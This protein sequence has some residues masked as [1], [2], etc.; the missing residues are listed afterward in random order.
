MT[1]GYNNNIL[2]VNLTNNSISSEQPDETFFR[3]YIGGW[4]IVAYYLLRETKPGIDPLSPDNK[5]IFATSPLS[6]VTVPGSGRHSVGAKSPLT[7]AFGTAEVGGFWGTELKHSGFDAIIIE[8]MASKPV[9]LW[10]HNSVAEIRSAINLWGKTTGD[11]EAELRS[12]LGDAKIKVAAIG[13]AGET[14]V[15]YACIIHDRSRAAGRGGLGAVMG[16]KNLKAIA[17]RGEQAPKVSNPEILRSFTRTI[18]K[19]KDV[20]RDFKDTGTAGVTTVLNA[21]GGLPTRNFQAGTFDLAEE[22]SGE[23]MRDTILTGRGTCAG[24][25]VSCKREVE[26]DGDP[27]KVDATYGGPEYETIG[28]FGSNCGIGSLEMVAKANELCNAY[29]LD[30]ISTGNVIGFAMECFEAGLLTATMTNGLDLRFGNEAA[31]LQAIELLTRRQ[32]IGQMLAEGVKRMSQALGPA[33][34]PLAMEV[35]GLEIPM[36]EPRTKHGFGLG[37]ALSPTG[38]DHC[39]NVHDTM[40]SVEGPDMERLRSVGIL[41]PLPTDDLSSQKIRLYAYDVIWWVL[42]NILLLCSNLYNLYSHTQRA[43]LVNAATGWNSTVL[44]LAKVGERALTMARAYNIR[45]GLTPAD[46]RL[47]KRFFTHTE[48]TQS[49]AVPLRQHEFDEA[50]KLYYGMM[51]WDLKTGAPSQAKL[52]EL[53]IGWVGEEIKPDVNA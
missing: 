17:V 12:E 41:E 6:A 3:T 47:P 29:G 28:A 39:H 46:D 20:W 34:E 16:S 30:T 26:I 8:G 37:Y 48:G 2:R 4:N 44:E 22:I 25:P 19:D 23:E 50:L 36:H 14:M 18:N 42:D 33:A 13:P 51:G 43:E 49:T 27:Y 24:C 53:G 31:V 38:A 40:Y 5:L 21:M 45:E 7:G 1:L 35:K 52:E 11:T 10:I 32:G 9:Y 15:R